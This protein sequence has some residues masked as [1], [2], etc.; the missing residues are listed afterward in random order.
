M[1]KSEFIAAVRALPY[2][3]Y[4]ESSRIRYSIPM[5]SEYDKCLC[6]INAVCFHRK[7]KVFDNRDYWDAGVLLGLDTNLSDT[8][9][10]YADTMGDLNLFL[11]RLEK[12]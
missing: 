5:T 3:K 8:I 11:S 2:E 7:G 6:P 4:N 10:E 12:S 1:T 9:A